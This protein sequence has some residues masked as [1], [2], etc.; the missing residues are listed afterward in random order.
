MH[1][2][3]LNEKLKSHEPLLQHKGQLALA[4]TTACLCVRPKPKG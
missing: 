3:F 4:K 2:G 1:D